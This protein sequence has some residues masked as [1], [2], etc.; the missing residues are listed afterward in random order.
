[1]KLRVL[2]GLLCSVGCL[3]MFAGSA[4]A[5]GGQL[6]SAEWGIPGHRVDV[7]AQV[8]TF[9]HDGTLRFDAT[10]FNLGVDPAPHANKELIIRVRHWHGEVEA[11]N[12]PERSTV[13]LELDPD[14]GYERY[15]QRNDDRDNHDRDHDRDRDFD[16]DRHEHGVQIWRAYYGAEGQFVNVTDAVRAHMDGGRLFLHVDNYNL[17]VDPLPGHR[18]W[19]RL[20]YSVDGDRRNVVVEEKSDLQL[21]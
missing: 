5:Q 8:R 15:A 11:F 19:L 17:G 16:H 9:I 14:G 18:K 6:V 3:L 21:P 2:A 10:R 13:N 1:M 20:L 7:T 4:A 12:Y